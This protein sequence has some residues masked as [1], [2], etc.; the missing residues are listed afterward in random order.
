MKHTL[1]GAQYIVLYLCWIR[2]FLL[3]KYNQKYY[4]EKPIRSILFH[5]P[6]HSSLI[7]I[8]VQLWKLR[9]V[10]RCIF[11]PRSTFSALDTF[12]CRVNLKVVSSSSLA[13]QSTMMLFRMLSTFSRTMID[14]WERS[15]LLVI[16]RNA[17][18][19]ERSLITSRWFVAITKSS[20]DYAT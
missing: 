12:F 6:R 7:H 19:A 5:N 8:Q 15:V 4:H 14:F 10:T 3:I 20:F 16:S 11:P 1:T 13:W 17:F 18:N 2:F 9:S